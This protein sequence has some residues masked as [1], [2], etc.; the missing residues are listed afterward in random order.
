MR[1]KVY[2][3]VEHETLACGRELRA[4]RRYGLFALLLVV[5]A[6]MAAACGSSGGDGSFAEQEEPTEPT[7]IEAVQ[8]AYRTTT[9][10]KTAKVAFETTISGLPVGPNGAKA[11]GQTADGSLRMIGEG[12]VDFENQAGSTTMQG[13]LGEVEVRTIGGT[14]YQRMPEAFRAQM[15][16]QKPWIRMDLDEMMREQYGASLSELQGNASNDPAQQ[17]GYLR[18]VSDSVEEIGSEEIRGVQTTHYRAEVDLEKAAAEQEGEPARQAYEKLEQ[19]LG[20]STLPVDVWID[21]EGLVRRYEMSMD[22]PLPN[23]AGAPSSPD[24]ERGGE[25]KVTVAQEL[26]DFGTPVSVEP[27][28]ADQ[29]ADFADLMAAEQQAP[30]PR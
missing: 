17:L 12:V 27:P 19:Q 8:V 14:A 18:G 10:A 6:V 4:I 23:P 11:P 3:E 30:G 25:A 7:P 13:P 5:A 21:D 20:Q 1:E 24:A 9:E 2:G 28:P 29:T 26:Y 15:P 22:M 16:G